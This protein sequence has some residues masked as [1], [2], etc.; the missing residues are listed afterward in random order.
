MSIQCSHQSSV[1]FGFLLLKPSPKLTPGILRRSL[2]HHHSLLP[3]LHLC[4]QFQ[5]MV[6]IRLYR[7]RPVVNLV[8][9]MRFLLRCLTRNQTLMR[10]HLVF[11]ERQK[12]I[13]AVRKLAHCER[14]ATLHHILDIIEIPC[15]GTLQ[16]TYLLLT[17]VVL[18][19][20]H[21]RLQYPSVR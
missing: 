9:R 18:R 7:L 11:P 2:L 19:Y 3:L 12:L 13:H 4:L 1:F 17:Q 8:F 14:I 6:K 10:Q 5:E 21:V 15:H 20:R 16:L